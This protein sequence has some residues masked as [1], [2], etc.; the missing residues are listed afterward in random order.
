M[1]A[2]GMPRGGRAEGHVLCPSGSPPSSLPFSPL[3]VPNPSL[4]SAT[5]EP[6]RR[7]PPLRAG[8]LRHH[9]RPAR[10]PVGRLPQMPRWGGWQSPP[11]FNYKPQW[12]AFRLPTSRPCPS[13][14]AAGLTQPRWPG[15]ATRD[16]GP[17][18]GAAAICTLFSIFNKLLVWLCF[19][20]QG[21]L[22]FL[23]TN[24]QELNIG[25]LF[26]VSGRQG[27]DLHYRQ[28]R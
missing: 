8:K 1:T 19:S 10:P 7:Q 22:P 25:W 2:A 5:R 15:R 28:V 16:P 9:E 4:S 20:L 6:E 17:G 18:D 13:V 23:I 3:H 12:K 26:L 11:G 21:G 14:G 27:S 24:M